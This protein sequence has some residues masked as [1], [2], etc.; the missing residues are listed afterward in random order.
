MCDPDTFVAAIIESPD[1]SQADKRPSPRER[2]YP[3]SQVSK[4]D[5]IS[6]AQL[7]AEV[8]AAAAGLDMSL[9]R[10]PL[11]WSGDLCDFDQPLDYLGYDG[12]GGIGSG[13]ALRR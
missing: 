5:T 1:F 3:R 4:S 9:I 13:P 8:E 6:I 7:A 2:P 10:L 12:G 11:G